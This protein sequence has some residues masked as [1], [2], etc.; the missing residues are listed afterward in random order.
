MLYK[1]GDI[2]WF[3]FTYGGQR[4]RESTG[5]TDR[6]LALQVARRRRAEVEAGQP[7]WRNRLREARLVDLLA[8]EL[9]EANTK[10]L[11]KGYRAALKIYHDHLLEFF[12]RNATLAA[13]TYENVRE[14]ERWRREPRVLPAAEENS[15]PKTRPG[16]RGQTIRE[17]VA[18][19]K[20]AFARAR[21]MKLIRT[22]L[23]DWPEI[24]SDPKN[25]ARSGKLVP[26]PVLAAVLHHLDE[27]VRE[28]LLFDTLTG[29]RKEE[30]CEVRWSWIAKGPDGPVMHVPAHSRKAGSTY[31]VPLTDKAY[32]IAVARRMR[33]TKA[34][35]ETDLPLFPPHDRR[36][37]ILKALEAAKAPHL[38]YRD[39]RATYGTLMEERGGAVA[40]RD[41]LGHT[42]LA[43]TNLYLKATLHQRRE[44]AQALEAD[45]ED[46]LKRQE[47]RRKRR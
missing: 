21:R 47:Q 5:E 16:V 22:E 38:T 42:E 27:E 33:M 26:I 2:W 29:L 28:E 13:V 8:Y 37:R 17:E 40:A 39:L 46:A 7:S 23:E 34:A 12:G 36:K 10:Q 3:E 14:Y 43:T 30:L 31:A 20:R 11:A 6:R 15:P 44:A 45:L 24:R 41:S 32:K 25:E 18:C 4:F 1:R 35:R 9:D 19:L